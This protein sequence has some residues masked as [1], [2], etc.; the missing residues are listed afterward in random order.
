MN[1]LKKSFIS[2]LIFLVL[3]F[4]AGI[5]PAPAP[6]FLNDRSG[7]IIGSRSLLI[8][9]LVLPAGLSGAG[10]VIS[11]ADSGL[12]RGSLEEIH[13]DLEG[14]RVLRLESYSDRKI[15]DDPTGHGTHMAA[16]LVG[17]GAASDGRYR[18]IA[19]GAVLYFQALLDQEDELALPRHLN[20]LLAPAYGSGARI[21]VNGWGGT[22]NDYTG[23]SYQ[24]DYFIH[25]NPDF[26]TIFGAGNNG[27]T[28]GSLTAEAN[29]KN[30][31]TVGSSQ[32]PRPAYTPEGRYADMIAD[33]S[34]RGPAGDG[35]I[36]PE[37][38]TPGSAVISACS[39]LVEGNFAANSYYSRKGGSSMAAAVTGGAAALLRE[40]LEKAEHLHHPTSALMKALLVN[41]ARTP[42]GF[43]SREQGFGILD[44]S[45]TVLALQEGTFR[46]QDAGPQLASGETWETSYVVGPGEAD[47]K[48]TLAWTDPPA[49][50][51]AA[52][53]LVNNLD[54]EVEAPG[55]ILFY[56]NDF[57]KQGQAD[58]LNNI[59]QVLIPGTEPGE[60]RIRVSA[61]ELELESSRQSFALV[62]GQPLQRE[63]VTRQ[64][65]SF[66]FTDGGPILDLREKTIFHADDESLNRE[67]Q[68]IQRG[69]E[70]YVAPEALYIFTR[71]W[72]S[73]GI[74]LLEEQEEKLFLEINAGARDGGYYLDPGM[75]TPEQG[76]LPHITVN[77]EPVKDLEE[78]PMGVEVRGSIHPFA[79]TLWRLEA[80][81]QE[82]SGYITEISTQPGNIK[83]F[84]DPRTYSLA[85]WTAVAYK[86]KMID[87]ITAEAPYGSA[88]TARVNQLAP[89]M[90]VRLTLS[91]TTGLVQYVEVERQM[92]VGTIKEVQP[93]QEKITLDTGKSYQLFPGAP[94]YKDKELV[95][96]DQLRPG[97]RVTAMLLVDTESIIQLQ[98][99]S[100]ITYGRVVFYSHS[101]HTLYIINEDNLF[102]SFK[103]TEATEVFRWKIA[104]DPT[105]IQ[106]GSWVRLILHPGEDQVWRVDVAEVGREVEGK[107]W[108]FNP[109]NQVLALQDGSRYIYSEASLITKSGYRIDPDM[110][111]PGE[112][113]HLTTLQA[114]GLWSEVLAQVEVLGA[115]PVN[116][117]QLE[118]KAYS[119]RG[120]LII[121]GRTTA[122]RLYLYRQDGSRD[123]LEIKADGSI[124]QL[125]AL[126]PGEEQFFLIA[127]DS[128]TK[129]IKG[130]DV[131]IE[132]YSTPET[133]T[134]IPEDSLED[135]TGHPAE[136]AIRALV[137][138]GVVQGDGDGHFYPDQ[139][140]S[141]VL[142]IHMLARSQDWVLEETSPV[143]YFTDSSLIP[144]WATESVY[145]AS[146]KNVIK[147]YPDGALRPYEALSR[148][149]LGV[150]LSRLIPAT[151]ESGAV[152]MVRLHLAPEV[153]FWAENSFGNL[154]EKGWL[155]WINLGHYSLQ[156]PVARGEAATVIARLEEA[157]L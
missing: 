119:L 116:E 139:A 85:P 144:W 112:E 102:Q 3:V 87:T 128:S 99:N 60:Y 82:V 146:S 27:P 30:A 72:D 155:P 74:Q 120:V 53:T 101:D 93:G 136:A 103:V 91:P 141:R 153:P 36:K 97:N 11:L 68:A 86:D 14:G 107:V 37:L 2:M 12:D 61:R 51:G 130:R 75:L 79:Q 41:G 133:P 138:R 28:S 49:R 8:E 98:A 113:V 96:L 95:A 77:G 124:S 121:Q 17:S 55:G 90:K 25:R 58:A 81:F 70:I 4:S 122:D 127:L 104:L 40:Y 94:V 123:I 145:A 63:T 43:P 45:G 7:D 5:P 29:S 13:P 111:T 109:Y 125:Y 19:P 143:N 65:G 66:L 34:S 150:I 142:F 64:E 56:G 137:S 18:G 33:S 44:L 20:D 108:S 38:L 71:T 59:E 35:R 131:S 118:V 1:R 47:L 84:Q 129:G 154:Y 6:V 15:A 22:P 149:E 83:L 50:P 106:P 88:Q 105:S 157:G 80:S 67:G 69:S 16:T 23:R 52:K 147:G 110:I 114:P 39:S 10:Q 24:I 132:T 26:L 54:L 100:R 76:V 31:L 46:Y 117:P 48:I 62:W 73:G 57:K 115:G 21:Q 135:I 126:L 78:I 42:E 156:Q 89:G 92:V 9:D 134:E 32:V 151:G 152:Q 148:S 140:I